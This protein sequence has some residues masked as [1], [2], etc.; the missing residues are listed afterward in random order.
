MQHTKSPNCNWSANARSNR[1]N[2]YLSNLTRL[3]APIEPRW[4][5]TVGEGKNGWI[6]SLP[7]GTQKSLAWSSSLLQPLLFSL[8]ERHKANAQGQ[9]QRRRRKM[10][11]IEPVSRHSY[12]GENL[13]Y[14][15]AK[16]K[17]LI[18]DSSDLWIKHVS[19]KTV[20]FRW[21]L[22]IRGLRS[23]IRAM[24]QKVKF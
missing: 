1:Q 7:I 12:N 23:T 20:V 9:K 16:I 5:K 8:M 14:S 15:M 3:A 19:I 2:T 13:M 11:G 10:V 17:L 21:D 6:L 22:R 4:G 24:V 18:C